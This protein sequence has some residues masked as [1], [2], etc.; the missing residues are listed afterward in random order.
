MTTPQAPLIDNRRIA[1]RS[2]AELNVRPWLV[3]TLLMLAVTIVL[4]FTYFQ[5]ASRE[6]RL[7]AIGVPTSAKVMEIGL[8]RERQAS[9]D[10]IVNV[11]LHYTDPKTQREIDSTGPLARKAGASV[12][13]G[14][15]LPIRVD[16]DRPERWTDRTQPVPL[17]VEMTVPLMLIPFV[18]LCLI[19]T[20]FQAAR[21]K[22][23]IRNGAG[24]RGVVV[25]IKQPALA[26]MSKQIGV[27]LD[28]DRRIRSMYWPARNGP[29][30]KGT[31]I[32]VIQG[33]NGILVPTRSYQ[34]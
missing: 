32:D 18:A 31:P 4:S 16:P 29:I 8:Q 22:R 17:G 33:K 27:T 14:D 13:I 11:K 24:T 1:A 6:R 21:V 30:E 5:T 26:P 34:I 23:V 25:S 28:N 9:R 15:I 3:L 2:W 12:R 7:I 19:V 20:F 10:D